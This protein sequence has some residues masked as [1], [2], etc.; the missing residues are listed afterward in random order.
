MARSAS[1]FVVLSLLAL[2][3]VARAQLAITEI[4]YDVPGSDSGREWIEVQ[5]TGAAS[6]ALS[7]W[8]LFEANTNHGLTTDGS[9]TLAPGSFAIIADDPAK[10]RTD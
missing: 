9:D 7:E 6:I 2:P 8:K 3:I 1:T 4:M 5:N 10:F